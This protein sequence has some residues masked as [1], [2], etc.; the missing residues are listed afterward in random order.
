MNTLLKKYGFDANI[1]E[2]EKEL[3]AIISKKYT[4]MT[5][6]NILKALSFIDLT[7]LHTSDTEKYIADFTNKVNSFKKKYPNYPLPASIC[8]FPNFAKTVKENLTEKGVGITTVAGCFPSSQ[9]FT[10]VKELEC[11]HAIENGATE[12]DIVLPHSSFLSEDY[13]RTK[14]EL[15]RLRAAT[16]GRILKV[17]LES[18]ALYKEGEKMGKNPIEIIAIASLLSLE[19]GA[20]FIKTSTGKQEPAATPI[21]ALVMCKCI[22]YFYQING[23]KRGFKPAG[24]ISTTD[25]AILYLTIVKEILGEEWLTPNLFRIGASSLSDNLIMSLE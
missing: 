19:C 2:T 13:E 21:A 22:K 1:Y 6:D 15:T 9:S 5:K 23:E 7:S 4:N 11:K 3:E 24:G 12:I 17:I 20:D 10:D 16:K 25:D 18:G 8:V 14:E